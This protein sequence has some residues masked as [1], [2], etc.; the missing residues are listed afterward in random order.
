MNRRPISNCHEPWEWL[1]VDAAGWVQPCCW[2]SEQLGNLHEQ[3]IEQIWN[4]PDMVRLRG[5]IRDGYIDRICR[6]AGC[7]F[8]QDTVQAFGAEA[9]DDYRC[10]FDQEINLRASGRTEHCVS[11]WS[12]REEWGV[13]SDG[14]KATLLLDL[15]Q[16]PTSDIRVELLCRGAGH[17]RHPT[18][19]IGIEVNNAPI[20]RWE[21]H[22][23]ESTER[24]VWR[25]LIV[26]ADLVPTRRLAFG[27]V[28]AGPIRP[29][30]LDIPD[31]RLLGIGLSAVRVVAKDG[32]AYEDK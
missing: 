10:C 20:D 17:E 1:L 15:E 29:S 6:G 2:A 31:D 25:H 5:A 26:P 32:P 11:G 7:S 19:S 14:H 23:P 3:T 12:R 8:V 16:R 24:S 30:A 27:F 28:I 22:Y 9:F 21:F 18:V 13:W 4:G